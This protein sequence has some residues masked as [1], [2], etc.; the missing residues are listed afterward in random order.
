M[1]IGE[2]MEWATL[3]R[4]CTGRNQ[5]CDCYRQLTDE[6]SVSRSSRERW[7]SVECCGLCE[8]CFA[9]K[10]KQ[11]FQSACESERRL[12]RRCS[13][14]CSGRK[15]KDHAALPSVAADQ[16]IDQTRAGC[17]QIFSIEARVKLLLALSS[18]WPERGRCCARA[19]T[20]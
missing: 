9:V 10:S 13:L 11:A 6:R 4:F 19:M 3:E 20:S 12:D 14:G 5:T 16:P 1:P 17:H 8:K 7:C 18:D 15:T 2:R